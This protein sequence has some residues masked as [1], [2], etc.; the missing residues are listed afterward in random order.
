MLKA[1]VSLLQVSK[2]L[3]VW[4]QGAQ[5]VQYT[6]KGLA[7]VDSWGPLRYAMNA[8]LLAEIWAKQIASKS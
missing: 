2:F 3:E 5:P 8:A 4:V 7:W 1:L 6:P